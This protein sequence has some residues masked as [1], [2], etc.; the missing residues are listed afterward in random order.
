LALRQ[1]LELVPVAVVL[2]DKASQTLR[3]NQRAIQLLA[4]QTR[5]ESPFGVLPEQAGPQWPALRQLLM[6][7]EPTHRLELTPVTS[8]RP[9]LFVD[10]LPLADGAGSVSVIAEGGA[11]TAKADAVVAHL[12]HKLN[13]PL[14]TI[15]MSAQLA[16]DGKAANDPERLNRLLGKIQDN[17]RRCGKIIEQAVNDTSPAESLKSD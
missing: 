7:L 17:A 11:R 8:Q 9:A 4:V 14:S 3:A 5:P 16:A 1:V 12:A 2:Y 6:S 10:I 13:N 15:L